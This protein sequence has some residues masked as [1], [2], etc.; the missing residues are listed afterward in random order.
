MDG[1][2]QLILDLDPART[3]WANFAARAPDPIEELSA[4][5]H[6]LRT[7]IAARRHS[8][9][10]SSATLKLDA[11]LEQAA[12][13]LAELRHALEDKVD[14]AQW[15]NFYARLGSS[16]EEMR[17]LVDALPQPVPAGATARISRMNFT[18]AGFHVGSGIFSALLYHFFLTR[19]QGIL[20]I[21]VLVFGFLS[22]EVARR[23]WP[24][25]NDLLMASPL[26]KSIA[27]PHEYVRINSSTYFGIGL[28]LATITCPKVAVELGCVVLAIGDPVASTLGRRFGSL[29]LYRDKSW[30]GFVAFFVSGG[31]SCLAYLTLLHPDMANPARI[32]LVAASAGAVAELLTTRLDDNL[33]I[34]L[35]TALAASLLAL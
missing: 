4:Q 13:T 20:L 6:R 31:L 26:I 25:F 21:S 33:T 11:A 17:R 35:T 2:S 9:E 3:T 23:R 1:L 30:V 14:A 24:S 18:R 34:P 8:E 16:Y 10:P 29:K 27:R 7:E 22:M 12:L 32:A 15:R 5:M 28:L 19:P